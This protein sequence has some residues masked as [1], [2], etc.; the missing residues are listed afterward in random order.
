[1]KTNVRIQQRQ[2]GI[3][4]L[5][6]LLLMGVLL[7]VSSSLLNVTLKQYQLSGIAVTSEIA[8]QAANAGM[9]CALYN[10]FPVSP[11]ESV[12]AVP[13]DG[14]EQLIQPQISCM[15]ATVASEDDS[16][17]SFIDPDPS[18]GLAVSGGEQQFEIEWGN[19]PEVCTIVSVY[20]FSDATNPV[21]VEVDGVPMRATQCPAG[22]VCTVVQS[23]GYN[24]PCGEVTSATRVV[25]REYTQVY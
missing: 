11:A 21:D 22:S 4:L 1:M 10:D 2:D 15:G 25:E 17:G 16:N 5:V 24:V 19:N 18:N 7:G 12:F 3:T 23:R 13:S 14:S 6:T 9:E 8:F 20:K